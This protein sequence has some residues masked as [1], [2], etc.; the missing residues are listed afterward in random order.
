MAQITIQ[1]GQTLGGIAKTQGTSVQELLK[2]NPNI[3][4]PD[5]IF[6]GANL[7]TP[8]PTPVTP[9]APSSVGAG[10]VTVPETFDADSLSSTSQ[11]L[12]TPQLPEPPSPEP[13]VSSLETSIKSI[14]DLF[15]QFSQPV[16]EAQAEQTSLQTK[17]EE[18][19][20]KLETKA[21]TLQAKEA[22]LGVPEDIKKLKELNLQIAQQTGEFNKLAQAAEGQAIPT[23]IIAGQQ[24][25]IRRQQAVEIGALASV[26]QAVQGNV[27]LSQQT[28]QKAVD[29][30][31]APIEQQILNLGTFL[32]LNINKLSAAEKKQASKVQF[33][34]DEKIRLLNEQ[35][36]DK[37][38]IL[39]FASE[40]AKNGAPNDL[41]NKIIKTKTITEAM[42][43]GSEFLAGTEQED[44]QT[45]LIEVG[46]N[47]KLINTLTGEV[48]KD[49][50]P[51]G[52]ISG[53]EPQKIGTDD[54]GNDIFGIFDPITKTFDQ[55]PV[56]APT[57]DFGP[58]TVDQIAEAIRTIESNNNYDISGASG[59]FGAYQFMPGT[60]KAW[61]DEYLQAT[62]QPPG[63]L[64]LTKENQDAVAKFK[65]G[66]L[67]QQGNSAQEI[68][69]IWNSGGP[70]FE[71]KVGV[72]KFGVK[73]D[74]PAYVNKF[75]NALKSVQAQAAPV[76]LEQPAL[77]SAFDFISTGFTSDQSKNLPKKFNKL[78]K[79]GQTEQAKE[80]LIKSAIE[81]APTEQQNKA[82]GRSE[83]LDALEVITQD[84][85]DFESLGGSTG[86]FTG[87]IEKIAN[88]I[89]KTTDPEL[90]K[91]A[92]KIRL[93]IISY[94]KAVSGA[95]FTP[96]ESAEYEALFPSVGK[97][98][99]FNKSS[100]DSLLE[101]FELNQASFLKT[102]MGKTNFD[103]LFSEEEE[104]DI[105]SQL[106]PAQL[107]QLQ[108]E[109][110][111]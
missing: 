50:G 6:A 49:F 41:V 74:V 1:P 83:A 68:A 51:A 21:P 24:A 105:I 89:G 88:K 11:T 82:F 111:L 109:N 94:R 3:T 46:G 42:Q 63:V 53:Q 80:F 101:T 77:E 102:Q 45:Q 81:T 27:A 35:K 62:G 72:N 76:A 61:T 57:Q 31:F 108:N 71:G 29:L 69:S 28:A 9:A 15:K 44:L 92:N 40:A 16:E 2:L 55:V 14:D 95:A 104:Q 58:A 39:N 23:P 73:F 38:N 33:A 103:N 70:T 8:D 79:A 86:F 17:L 32:E 67:V 7:V 54:N 20:G 85:A 60:W 18:A 52:A 90:A 59:E 10:G 36:E 91:I 13:F 110:L 65:I 64:P 4:N 56:T 75:S 107:Q 84:I 37:I 93:S 99:N 97:V 34:L 47:K 5:L 106:S 43:L 19:L 48:I 96:S 22:E 26:A 12:E 66:Q 87:S 98:K 100:I 78:L 25:Q 30:E